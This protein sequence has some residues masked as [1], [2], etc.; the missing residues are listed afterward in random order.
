ML[1]VVEKILFVVLAVGTLALA[2][3]GF[4]DMFKIVMRGEDDLVLD[5]LP[6]RAIKALG[7][8]LSQQTTL[9]TRPLTSLLH[10]G[11]VWGFTFYFLVNVGDGLE[12]YLPDFQ[13]LGTGLIGD[14]YRLL[15]D[16]LTI[17]VLVGVVYFL[18]RRFV[19][20]DKQLTFHENV[21]LHPKV[22]AGGIRRDSLI[23]AVFILIHV[24]SRFLGSS[25][26]VQEAIRA[27]DHLAP[28]PFAQ[29]VSGV[30]S[31][32]SD[33]LLVVL[34]HS[35]WWIALGA[36]LLF[37]PYFPYSKHAHLFMAPLN[38]LTKPERSSLGA[39]PSENFD[40]E[41]KEQFGAHKLEQLPKTHLMDAFA[42][43]MCNR[44]QDV[45]PAYVTGKELSPSAYEINKRYSIRDQMSDLAA[46]KD[47]EHPLLGWAITGSAVWAC[48][49]C[50]A[51]VD[52]CPVG[53]EPM[54]D[55]L[56]IRRDQGVGTG[57][58]FHRNL[59]ARSMAWSV[60][61]SLADE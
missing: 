12:G 48:T 50:G 17:A 2:Y 49:S 27:G 37:I 35:F 21:L 44:C 9:K 38:F 51:C 59:R 23:V 33:D 53:N 31:G 13:F 14:V 15:A 16:L 25:V 19:W 5:N 40:D 32:S 8:Y 60:R 18:L 26:Q 34:E 1:T 20:K 57:V 4:R 29:I 22:K 36:I 58:N 47:S 54:F 24:G 55:I 56:D 41:A 45:C 30:W 3:R 52:I 46:G 28:Q 11:V 7:L 43:I 10:L 42:C 6:S 61:Q 39:L